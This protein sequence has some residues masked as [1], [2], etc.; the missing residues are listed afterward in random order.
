MDAPV[1]PEFTMDDYIP[2][3]TWVSIFSSMVGKV[4]WWWLILH[5]VTAGASILGR[6][7]HQERSQTE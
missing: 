7:Q 1:I 3:I 6:E 2:W 5:L 4:V